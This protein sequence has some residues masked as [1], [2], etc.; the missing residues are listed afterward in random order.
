[1]NK[2]SA[3]RPVLPLVIGLFLVLVC[4]CIQSSNQA[5]PV[6]GGV[7]GEYLSFNMG[8]IAMKLPVPAG[9]TEAAALIRQSASLSLTPPE[10]IFSVYFPRGEKAPGG[11]AGLVQLQN[12]RLYTISARPEFIKEYVDPAFFSAL[13]R[14]LQRV[15]GNFGPERLQQFRVLT[16]SYY[17]K[18]ES[19][20]HSLGVYNTSRY[21]L[22]IVR[23]TRQPA[24]R[25]SGA[26]SAYPAAPKAATVAEDAPRLVLSPWD[27][28]Y[29]AQ[30]YYQVSIHNVVML[31]GRYLNIYFSAPLADES[32]IYA[33]MQENKDYMD[34]LA[35]AAAAGELGAKNDFNQRSGQGSV[36]LLPQTRSGGRDVAAPSS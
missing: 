1:M 15:N 25:G 17:A 32:D 24:S 22:S 2:Y 7:S 14:D 16:N 21:S 34:G 9:Y 13:R 31:N 30:A 36:G 26:L 23:I 35:R 20:T 6:Q 18:D 5:T 3:V 11:K 33:A 4:G 10:N 27:K 8:G 12:R 28:S 19:F 29:F